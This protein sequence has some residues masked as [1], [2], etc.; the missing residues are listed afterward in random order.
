MKTLLQLRSLQLSNFHTTE[1]EDWAFVVSGSPGMMKDYVAENRC[2]TTTRMNLQGRRCR[3][4]VA[5]VLGVLLGV[6]ITLWGL[7]SGTI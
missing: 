7:P 6:M 5:L 4:A 1:K 2:M 3:F